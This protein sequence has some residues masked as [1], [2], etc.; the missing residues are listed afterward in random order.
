MQYFGGIR[1]GEIRAAESHRNLV[2]AD[3]DKIAPGTDE[4]P[5]ILIGKG[6]D[7][8]VLPLTGPTI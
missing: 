4:R 2:C 7:V 5:A 8:T 1:S 6:Y 3:D